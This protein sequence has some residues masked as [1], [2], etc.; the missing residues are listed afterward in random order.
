MPPS[1]FD[2]HGLRLGA[3]FGL[4]QEE[5][6][7][8]NTINFSLRQ[9]FAR[10]SYEIEL[11][12]FIPFDRSVFIFATPNKENSPLFT[13]LVNVDRIS[14]F[15]KEVSYHDQD[16]QVG[17]VNKKVIF[18]NT[19]IWG[20]PLFNQKNPFL[21]PNFY[22]E[23]RYL[24]FYTSMLPDPSLMLINSQ[25][26]PFTESKYLPLKTLQIEPSAYIDWHIQQVF[27]FSW[28]V[29]FDLTTMYWENKDHSL[30]LKEG[31]SYSAQRLRS[32]LFF[33]YKFMEYTIAL[34][35]IVQDENHPTSPRL[36]PLY[37][38]QRESNTR[39][40]PNK[41]YF[42]GGS[43]F[44]KWEESEFH[45][46]G[47]YLNLYSKSELVFSYRVSYY[48]RFKDFFWG[49]SHMRDSVNSLRSFANFKTPASFFGFELKTKII[50]NLFEIGWNSHLAWD[51]I[52]R[53]RSR[54]YVHLMF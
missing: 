34:G 15:F 28:G 31:F 27:P 12:I 14:N 25:Y 48:L 24:N 46:F 5:T 47:I 53:L 43:F 50:H 52:L 42:Y 20:N 26:Q 22:L 21:G 9:D 33:L 39:T 49:I 51:D 40:Q 3:G 8:I 44:I 45:S 7:Y 2:I 54:L 1:L 29:G 32:T 13:S 37:V 4:W 10:I 41:H 35:G 38:N 30:G 16:I 23:T 6:R 17:F 11:P 19:L 36:S 18:Q